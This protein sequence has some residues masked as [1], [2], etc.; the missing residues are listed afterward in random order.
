M[1]ATTD[2]EA[3]DAFY[4]VKEGGEMV[5]WRRNDRW[6]GGSSMLLFQGEERK[7]SACFERGKEHAGKLLVLVRR[8]DQRMQ[9]HGGGQQ[10]ES[11][12]V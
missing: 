11:G 7:I 10:L 4:R 5:S 8:G 2:C 3:R 1:D 6:H 12:D 9:R